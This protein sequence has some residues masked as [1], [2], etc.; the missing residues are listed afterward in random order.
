M[1]SHTNQ[2]DALQ[3]QWDLSSPTIPASTDFS[4]LAL[5][6][7][8]LNPELFMQQSSPPPLPSQ[9]EC[10]SGPEPGPG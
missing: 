7:P 1:T 6:F 3:M 2:L 8:H 9:D 4:L 5:G 10:I